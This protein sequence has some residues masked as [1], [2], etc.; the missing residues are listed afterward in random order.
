MYGGRENEEQEET[1]FAYDYANNVAKAIV[2]E[3]K[4]EK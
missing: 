2:K 3:V 4:G 1:L